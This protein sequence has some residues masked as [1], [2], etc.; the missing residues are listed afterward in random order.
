MYELNRVSSSQHKS[1][2][3]PAKC[4][5]A[6]AS[7]DPNAN[8]PVV[9]RNKFVA[10]ALHKCRSTIELHTTTPAFQPDCASD[11]DDNGL[12]GGALIKPTMRAKTLGS[13]DGFV[14][15]MPPELIITPAQR[16]GNDATSDEEEGGDE[17]PSRRRV[18]QM[19]ADYNA[20]SVVA[21]LPPLMGS[22]RKAEGRAGGGGK[23]RVHASV[24]KSVVP[25]LRFELTCLT[26]YI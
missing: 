25:A 17:R 21:E 9:H 5:S 26:L 14:K 12:E 23:K 7:D 15:H 3:K 19:V 1:T 6:L 11:S 18:I 24:R 20:R 2:K 16:N 22:A 13:L 10:L 4:R 8:P